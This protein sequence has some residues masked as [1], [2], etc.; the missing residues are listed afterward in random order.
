VQ[1]DCLWKKEVQEAGDSTSD[2]SPLAPAAEDEEDDE[3]QVLED[4]LEMELDKDAS[5]EPESEHEEEAEEDSAAAPPKEPPETATLV[6]PSDSAASPQQSP[7]Q[8]NAA[9]VEDFFRARLGPP[10]TSH[11][12]MQDMSIE[13]LEDLQGIADDVSKGGNGKEA[14][15]KGLEWSTLIGRFIA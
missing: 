10:E 9:E 11:K 12:L 15:L 3:D 1:S 4:K 6:P 7:L 8:M 2:G 13:D 5:A 14:Q